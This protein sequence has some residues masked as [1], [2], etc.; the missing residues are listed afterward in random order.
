MGHASIINILTGILGFLVVAKPIH[1][2]LKF[3]LLGDVCHITDQNRNH[4][5]EI[6]KSMI[7]GYCSKE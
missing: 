3:N 1:V 2:S 7:C 6:A 5:V 4:E